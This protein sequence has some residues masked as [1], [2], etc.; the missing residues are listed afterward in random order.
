MYFTEFLV[1]RLTRSMRETM[2]TFARYAFQDNAK[3]VRLSS[4]ET[5]SHGANQ[6]KKFLSRDF[7]LRFLSIC[8][9]YAYT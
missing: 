4:V 8:I 5:I 7:D 2:I 6:S 1:T 3:V 9:E